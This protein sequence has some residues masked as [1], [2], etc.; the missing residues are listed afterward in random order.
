M[1]AGLAVVGA[2]SAAGTDL[3]ELIRQGL[4]VGAVQFV[5]DSGRL[6]LAE[7]DRIVL[8]AQDAGEPSKVGDPDA[9]AV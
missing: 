6:T 3:V 8:P 9:G 4:P 1:W 5:L 7:L 2:N